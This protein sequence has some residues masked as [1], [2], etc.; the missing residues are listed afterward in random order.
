MGLV[1]EGRIKLREVSMTLDSRAL[2]EDDA[3]L[4]LDRL[5]KRPENARITGPNRG[6]AQS[7]C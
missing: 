2:A 7:F 3:K 4:E 6:Q 1:A 5:R